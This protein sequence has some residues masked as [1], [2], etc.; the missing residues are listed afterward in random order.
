MVR[1]EFR[2]L[3]LTPKS[4]FRAHTAR[5]TRAMDRPADSTTLS[6][7]AT[8]RKKTSVQAKPGRK[9]TSRN[10]R[11]ALRNGTGSSRGREKSSVCFTVFSK[12]IFFST[13]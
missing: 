3:I 7:T 5:V 4:K 6:I 8:R 10:P 9:K 11:D 13:I 2:P 1:K 12:S